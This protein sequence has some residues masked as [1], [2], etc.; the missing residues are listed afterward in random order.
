M[1]MGNSP[2]PY[3]QSPPRPPIVQ[4]DSRRC[5]VELQLY[6]AVGKIRSGVEGSK[7]QR[8]MMKEKEDESTNRDANLLE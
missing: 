3:E 6:R 1:L 2:S 5:V 8:E 4:E 7:E